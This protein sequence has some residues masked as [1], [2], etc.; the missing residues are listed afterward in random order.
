MEHARDTATR[1]YDRGGPNAEY[2]HDGLAPSYGTLNSESIDDL[3]EAYKVAIAGVMRSLA[4]LSSSQRTVNNIET[5]MMN[6]TYLEPAEDSID[7]TE[8]ILK[9]NMGYF[10]VGANLDNAVVLTWWNK[11]IADQ[12]VL[13]S[14][15]NSQAMAN[16]VSQSGAIIDMS[17]Q[18]WSKSGAHEQ[19]MLD[20]GLYRIKFSVRVDMSRTIFPMGDLGGITGEFHSRSFKPRQAAIDQLEQDALDS[21]V[22]EAE[23]FFA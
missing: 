9:G 17:Q 10:N 3:D 20:I 12:D 2:L 18:F 11:L 15:I 16:I 22:Q 14:T 5:V 4:K 7:R 19:K 23:D 6:N 8:N 21:A 13:N 1:I